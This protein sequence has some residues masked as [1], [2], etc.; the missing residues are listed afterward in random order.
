M[1][2][3]GDREDNF[4]VFYFDLGATLHDLSLRGNLKG[5]GGESKNDFQIPPGNLKTF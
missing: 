4:H 1:G 5:G 3:I 2:R